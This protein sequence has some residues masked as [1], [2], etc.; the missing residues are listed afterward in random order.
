MFIQDEAKLALNIRQSIPLE[1]NAVYLNPNTLL[2]GRKPYIDSYW[3]GSDNPLSF[4]EHQQQ[5]GPEWKYYNSENSI[6]YR[7]NSN[8]H[9]T[10]MELDNLP[11]EW[12][13]ALGCSATECV[14]LP[15]E[16]AW[17]QNLELPVY[18]SGIGGFGQDAMLYNLQRIMRLVDRKP[19]YVFVQLSLSHRFTAFF[20][21]P[22]PSNLISRDNV[23][24]I[25]GIWDYLSNS[26]YAKLVGDALTT[27]VDRWR[28]RQIVETMQTICELAGSKLIIVDGYHEFDV[29]RN[30]DN[31][32]RNPAYTVDVDI[33]RVKFL[34]N[35]PTFHC[36]IGGFDKDD[37]SIDLSRDCFHRGEGYHQFMASGVKALM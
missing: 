21:E 18:N 27:G 36:D 12:G 2:I 24:K 26:S 33:E 32:P 31:T 15:L 25:C 37:H 3:I 19:K 1:H 5:F 6:H 11:K 13:L 8:G 4:N 10:N 9:R 16:S 30:R 17:H 7:Y 35:I 34:S 22:N 23:I 14:G 29:T 28:T 20:K